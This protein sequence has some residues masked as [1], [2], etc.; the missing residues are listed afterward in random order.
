[1][2]G[3]LVFDS[4]FGGLTIAKEIATSRADICI[5]YLADT[6]A[7]PYGGKTREEIASRV[8]ALLLKAIARLPVSVV[9]IAC[10]TAT[11]AAIDEIRK[12]IGLPV[13]GVV[14]AIKPACALTRTGTV[15]FW[16][17]SYTAY[18]QYS[19]RLIAAFAGS[20][21]VLCHGADPLVVQ[22]EN[23]L[24]SGEVESHIIVDQFDQYFSRD[25]SENTDIIVLGCTHFPLLQPALL[26]ALHR[27]NKPIQLIDSASAIVR[28]LTTVLNEYEHSK[29]GGPHTACCIYVTG[30]W[31]I[32]KLHLPNISLL[33]K[34]A[35][36]RYF[37]Q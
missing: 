5:Y 13:I 26:D 35:S 29:P 4:G 32:K 27:R 34:A 36:I 20:A 37:K 23:L 31:S 11:T 1:M 24:Y 18:S 25:G 15:G 33:L 22:A 8:V 6:E 10:N 3:V 16:A 14:P 30:E 2:T 21:K 9:V 28:R 19:K 7:F 12:A 17:T